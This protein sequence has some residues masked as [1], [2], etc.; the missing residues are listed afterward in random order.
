MHVMIYSFFL[1]F[2]RACFPRID[3][4]LISVNILLVV[5]NCLLKV[6]CAISNEGHRFFMKQ[7]RDTLFYTHTHNLMD[8]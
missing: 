1:I 7:G 8:L 6:G 3:K 4:S 5:K 2:A